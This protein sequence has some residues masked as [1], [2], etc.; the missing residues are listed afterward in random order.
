MLN[1][2][3]LWRLSIWKPGCRSVFRVFRRITLGRRMIGAKLSAFGHSVGVSHFFGKTSKKRK[4]ME[5]VSDWLPRIITSR[6]MRIFSV[7]LAPF[8]VLPSGLL[9]SK[10]LWLLSSNFSSKTL[11]SSRC[12]QLRKSDWALAS[13]APRSAPLPP[14]DVTN[15]QKPVFVL[16][17]NHVF[18]TCSWKTSKNAPIIQSLVRNGSFPS[19]GCVFWMN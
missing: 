8:R 1:T 4:N 2:D 9:D 6:P 19:S 15:C 18:R 16:A 3:V 12:S 13:N 11:N 5:K 14:F 10:C 7:F 17:A